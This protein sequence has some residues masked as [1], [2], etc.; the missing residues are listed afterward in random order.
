MAKMQSPST[1]GAGASIGSSSVSPG[2]PPISGVPDRV[3]SSSDSPKE[4]V[5]CAADAPPSSV[6]ASA[7]VGSAANAIRQ[8]SRS[9]KAFR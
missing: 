4:V 7:G 9:A 8:E 2:R 5:F 1:V 6:A 3:L